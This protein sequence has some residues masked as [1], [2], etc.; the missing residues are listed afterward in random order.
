MWVKTIITLL[1][2]LFIITPLCGQAAAIRYA[3]IVG[4]NVGSD[5]GSHPPLPKLLHAER[6]AEVL[7]NRLV[8]LSNFDITNN[9]ILLLLAPTRNEVIQAAHQ[10]AEQKRHDEKTY[11]NFD[12]F[13]AFFFT[14]HGKSTRLLLRNGPLSTTELASIF[15]AVGATFQVGVFDA[16]SSGSLEE[17]PLTIPNTPPVT[18]L[19]PWW[20]NSA[21]NQDEH[22]ERTYSA[23][24]LPHWWLNGV[25]AVDQ[26]KTKGI[27]PISIT[28]LFS[29]LP[30]DMLK[31]EGSIWLA[32]NSG[33]EVSYEDRRLGGLFTYFFIEAL[34][35]APRDGSGITLENIWNYVRRKTSAYATVQQR[36][37]PR[38]QL[39]MHLKTNAPLYFSLPQK[40]S[41]LLML[42]EDIEGGVSIEY[43]DS[44]F[45]DTLHKSKGSALIYQVFSGPAQMRIVT[46]GRTAYEHK[47]VFT[48]D[49]TLSLP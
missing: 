14:G 16:C 30:G 1:G 38:P 23:F 46:S 39:I 49:E 17:A 7:R 5:V 9:R 6:E 3:I 29:E 42:N 21:P 15:R 2:I 31:T 26:T 40:R 45:I 37:P 19:P 43:L 8:A 11:G 36:R 13:F 32:S 12:S 35:N 4:S 47:V 44:G 28:N 22:V 20:T 33:N 34:N 24:G 41:A 10:I 25:P 18:G 48:K 27:K